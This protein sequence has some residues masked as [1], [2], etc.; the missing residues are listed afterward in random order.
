MPLFNNPEVQNLLSSQAPAPIADPLRSIGLLQPKTTPTFTFP[1]GSA[2]AQPMARLGDWAGGVIQDKQLLKPL[3]SY[4]ASFHQNP[5]RAALLSA[6][7]LGAAGLGFGA[8]TDR[9]PYLMGAL[10]AGLGGLGGY[11][12]A[13]L[14]QSNVRRRERP[15]ELL[16]ASMYIEGGEDPMSYIQSRLFADDTMMPPRKSSLLM[17]VQQ[18]PP[19]QLMQLADVLRATFGAAVG[20]I[21]GRF[22]LNMGGVGTGVASGLGG[23]IGLASGGGGQLPRNAMGLSVDTHRDMFGNPRYL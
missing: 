17:A 5:G 2:E 23:L 8:M 20:Y 13:K 9:N 4:L 18:L 16:K 11:G 6:L 21:V 19:A 3:G 12:L 7:G 15:M 14:I 1:I 22:L 10:G